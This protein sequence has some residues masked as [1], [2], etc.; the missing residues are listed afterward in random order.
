MSA[1]FETLGIDWRLLIVYTV[2]FAVLAFILQRYAFKPMLGMLQKRQEKIAAS[3]SQAEELEK[4]T[5]ESQAELRKLLAGAQTEAKQIVESSRKEADDLR[6]REAEQLREDLE[7][8]RRKATADIAAERDATLRAVHT[9]VA[10][11]VVTATEKI[12]QGSL[13][14]QVDKALAEAALEDMKKQ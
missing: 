11:L 2:N 7:K 13:R 5:T 9:E 6:T 14:G 10:E 8:I 1:L 3:M 12:S 4:R